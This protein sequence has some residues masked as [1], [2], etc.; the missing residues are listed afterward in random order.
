MVYDAENRLVSA[1]GAKSAALSYDPLGRLVQ[2][3]GGAAGVTQ[4]LY[5]GDELVAEYNSAGTVLRRYVHGLGTDDPILWYE[6]AG[7]SD[8]RSLQANHQGSVIGVANS[9]GTSIAINAYDE[10]GVPNASNQG[11]FQYTGQ[12]WLPE[13]GMYHYKAR[14]YSPTLGRFLQT[15][16]VGYDD[17]IN[18]YAYVG[19]DPVNHRD[20]S[21]KQCTAGREVVRCTVT[22]TNIR[23]TFAK[24]PGW[25][26]SIKE[27]DRNYHSYSKSVVDQK[28]SASNGK[29]QRADAL[30]KAIQQNPTPG[31]DAPA[32]PEGTTNDASPAPGFPPGM[33]S[34]VKSYT[35]VDASGRPMVV[36]VTQPGHPLFP[37]YVARF[38]TIGQD[39]KIVANNVGEGRGALQ[40]PTSPL[41]FGR[42]LINN[43]WIPQTQ[44]IIDVLD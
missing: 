38:V 14:I 3:S 28:G 5:D 17:Q 42:N 12:A 34:P 2:T 39:G 41:G 30:A 21:G 10:W 19:N 4:F 16:P 27:G 1:S 44:A 32:S 18:L 22:G 15:D 36:N 31:V 35:R 43:V 24:P 6:G 13:L 26:S 29:T 9:S 40:S 37:G 25:P 33:P 11:R 7:L 8:R 20:P 23:F